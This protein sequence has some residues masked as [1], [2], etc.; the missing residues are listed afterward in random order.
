L[1]FL[2]SAKAR[3]TIHAGYAVSRVNSILNGRTKQF[4]G[5]QAPATSNHPNAPVYK[6]RIQNQQIP[7]AMSDG[8]T[9]NF[10]LQGPLG[11]AARET[12]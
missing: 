6:R 5:L 3:K 2:K 1:Q 4:G 7:A 11:P 10:A 9:P 8:A 12:L